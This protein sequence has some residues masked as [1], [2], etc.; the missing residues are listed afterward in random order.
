MP[1]RLNFS[2]IALGE[3]LILWGGQVEWKTSRED[4]KRLS[5]CLAVRNDPYERLLCR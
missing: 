2:I 1:D 4:W 5:A 3:N